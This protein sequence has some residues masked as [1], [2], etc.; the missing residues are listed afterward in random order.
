MRFTTPISALALAYIA[1]A[2]SRVYSAEPELDSLIQAEMA[3]YHI[4]GLAACVVRGGELAWHGEYGF[5]RLEDSIPVAD[6]TVFD[7][8]S[9]SKT[10]TAAALMQLCERGVFLT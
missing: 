5:A 3:T 4:P 2:T 10:A 7:L 6:S 1:F 8:A 9:V